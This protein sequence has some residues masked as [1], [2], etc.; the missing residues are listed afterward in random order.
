YR[1]LPPRGKQ[2]LAS[3]K[4]WAIYANLVLAALLV[5]IIP[6]GGAAAPATET[7]TTT[8]EAGN[9]TQRGIPAA[10]S[11][12]RIAV[13]EFLNE[14][15]DPETDWWG[16]AYSLLLTD[17]LLQRPEVLVSN[18]SKLNSY[19]DK[20]GETPYTKINLATQRKIAQRANTDYFV[21]AEYRVT[22]GSHEITGGLYRTKDGKLVKELKTAMDNGFR[23]VDKIKEQIDEY[24]PPLTLADQ[25]VSNLPSS[26]LITDR[27]EA[28]RAYSLGIKAFDLNPGDLPPAVARFRESTR[29]DPKCAP[30]YYNLADKLY[31]QGKT[32]SARMMNIRAVKLA[33]MLPEREQ[34]NY[35]AN[36]F[37]STGEYDKFYLLMES[38]RQLFPY[39]Y[40]PYAALAGY[41]ETTFGLDS[42]I[43]LMETAA[44]LSDRQTALGRLYN[45]Y[46]RAE[47]FDK[48]EQAIK[49]LDED[50]SETDNTQLRYANF[51]Q[52]SG[53]LAKA[54]KTLEEMISLDPLNL[55]LM[56]QLVS[57]ELEAGNYD[58]AERGIKV[59]FQQT[60]SQTDSISAWNYLVRSYAGRG[61]IAR[62]LDELAAYE[63]FISNKAPL[64]RILDQDLMTKVS[65][66][67]RLAEP[68][69][70]IQEKLDE[71]RPYDP[72]RVE[73][74]ECYI[75]LS[76]ILSDVN[77]L[78]SKEKLVG[79]REILGKIGPAMLELFD[80][81]LLIERKDYKSAADLVDR[82]LVKKA[83][84][85]QP[86]NYI[87][88]F[89]L[90]GRTDRAL[91][92]L[93]KARRTR[94]ND[95]DLLLE[96]ARLLQL[97][98]DKAAA[99]EAVTKVLATWNRADPGHRGRRQA[100]ELAAEL[101]METVE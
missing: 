58:A 34:I 7:V 5:F 74:Y 68:M 65:Y 94:P 12:Q 47:Q 72:Q 14:A 101:G 93:E 16:T 4:R 33:E 37:N 1:G 39:E 77:L 98:G 83:G 86:E 36:L 25:P 79:C 64:N 69:P 85:L 62:A 90:A 10:S 31:G 40:Y 35:K 11:V 20:L 26:A 53:Q 97:T 24:L 91:E 99:R 87:R 41:V 15:D 75:P 29:L 54:R 13:F 100:R 81:A 96:R 60:T 61:Q 43:T 76:L 67:S 59:I 55:D 27:P 63:N 28:L 2:K 56:T 48:A 3:W 50:Y 18:I 66:L 32:D 9:T 23:A 38:Y 45:L 89:R 92:L 30:C 52:E 21:R 57:L 95:P 46:I 44:E 80:I 17:D 73:I 6:E 19:Y 71:L 8:D 78:E 42:A 49:I 82:Q 84:F 51:Y 70:R 22:E 88:I